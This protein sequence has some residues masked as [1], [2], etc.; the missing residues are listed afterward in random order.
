[1]VQDLTNHVGD[2]STIVA[3]SIAAV[4][5]VLNQTAGKRDLLSVLGLDQVIAVQKHN[6][7]LKGQSHKREEVTFNLKG[8]EVL[9]GNPL[10]KSELISFVQSVLKNTPFDFFRLNLKNGFKNHQFD[11]ELEINIDGK[12]R[13]VVSRDLLESEVD[14]FFS[15]AKHLRDH[16]DLVYMSLINDGK[17]WIIFYDKV[18]SIDVVTS[19]LRGFELGYLYPIAQQLSDDDYTELAY[20]IVGSHVFAFLD[21]EEVLAQAKQ[22]IVKL[23]DDLKNHTANAST[24]IQQAGKDLR[25]LYA[26]QGKRD[27]AD[28][29]PTKDLLKGQEKLV[30]G[31][32]TVV[33]TLKGLTSDLKGQFMFYATQILFG[34]S[35][36]NILYL[37]L[38]YLIYIFIYTYIKAGK[39]AV[40]QAQGILAQLAQDLKDHAGNAVP[41]VQQA[42]AQL[43]QIVASQSGKRDLSDFILNAL[44]LST[45]IKTLQDLTSDLKGQ[46]MFFAT[47]T[48]FGKSIIN[49]LYLNLIYLIYIFI[50]TYIKAGEQAIAQAQRIFAQ[51]VKDLKGHAG[52]AVPLVQQAIAQLTQVL[53]NSGN[54]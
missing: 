31:L 6:D 46:L 8:F 24:I 11:N 28:F 44:G 3:N 52:N 36:I 39:Q 10:L 4:N 48:L 45:I 25:A 12:D 53:T 2:A 5:Q 16:F 51:L 22:I 13:D 15:I 1:M 14:Y 47:Q 38:I 42:I 20:A 40:A 50:Y 43:T 49:I 35:I 34:K 21:G 32:S 27:L 29:L 18:K 54:F 26:G 30:L 7:L 19:N 17:E 33:Q 37:N 9:Q 41:L 23:F